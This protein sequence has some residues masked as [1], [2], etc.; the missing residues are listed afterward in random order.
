[1]IFG[2]SSSISLN[3]GLQGGGAHGAFT[4]GVLDALLEDGRI[5]FDGVSATSAGAMNA[6]VL[7]HGL[8]QGGNDGARQALADFWRGVAERTP[9][10]IAIPSA[11]GKD[12]RLNPAVKMMLRWTHYLSPSQL[13]PFDFN[14]LRDILA[15]QVDFA[16]LRKH[17][18]IRLFIAATQANSGKLRLFRERELTVDAVLASACL[19]TI[20]RAVVIDG[21]PYWD[22][23]YSANPAVFPLIYQCRSQDIL[24]VL[25]TPLHHKETPDSAAD[26]KARTLDVAFNA[27]FLR[28]MRMFADLRQVVDAA[29][30]RIGRLERRI[31]HTRFHAI[32]AED[33][34][35]ELGAE[36]KLAANLQF[37]EMMREH[38]RERTKRWI[39]AKLPQLGRQSTIDLKKLFG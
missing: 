30:L 12:F 37:F 14:P 31:A 34:I 20:H 24:L 7:A 36:T 35:N 38:G 28:E 1:M 9:F 29:W 8:L 25:L 22:G 32:E 10:E 11:D 13:N 21:E 5:A 26:I 16:R 19:P 39:K 33:L 15:E 4:W 2:S 6:V 23:G 27:A 3:L 18:P 17:S